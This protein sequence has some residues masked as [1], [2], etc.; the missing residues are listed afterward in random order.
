MAAKFGALGLRFPHILKPKWAKVT[1]VLM[2]LTKG[3]GSMSAFAI[4]C[5]KAMGWTPPD[6]IEVPK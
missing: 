4:T 5:S 6:G 3:I 1:D 2:R